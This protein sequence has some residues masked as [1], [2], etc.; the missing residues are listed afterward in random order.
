M[1]DTKWYTTLTPKQ[2]EMYQ[3]RVHLRQGVWNSNTIYALFNDQHTLN[4]KPSNLLRPISL[5]IVVNVHACLFN[6]F[7]GIDIVLV[8]NCL[9]QFYSRCRCSCFGIIQLIIWN[10]T[11]KQQIYMIM[12]CRIVTH[13]WYIKKEVSY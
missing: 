8:H 9:F 12:V 6:Q 11:V 10:M 4:A 3:R 7:N 5:F 1:S 13:N 2:Q